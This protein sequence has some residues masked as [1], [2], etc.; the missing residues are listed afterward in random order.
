M[1][2]FQCVPDSDD[3]GSPGPQSRSVNSGPDSNP[4]SSG[5][6]DAYS[7]PF[8]THAAFLA[9]LA[10]MIPALACTSLI[11]GTPNGGATLNFNT[12]DNVPDNIIVNENDNSIFDNDNSIFGNDNE[13]FNDNGN[14]N[15][16]D[17]SIF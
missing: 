3:V 8:K 11:S 6:D 15:N 13:L 9:L 5:E 2:T 16:N 14:L 12:N 4:G 7:S 17:N 1:L 10:A